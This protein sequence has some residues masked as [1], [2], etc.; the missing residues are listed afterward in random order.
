MIKFLTP[1]IKIST[2]QRW[3]DYPDMHPV[4]GP[5]ICLSCYSENQ[6]CAVCFGYR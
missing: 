4:Y 2:G 1:K 5:L 6:S 3:S